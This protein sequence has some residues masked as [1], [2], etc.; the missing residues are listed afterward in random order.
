[1]SETKTYVCVRCD[2]VFP[3]MSSGRRS[4]SVCPSCNRAASDARA[5]ERKREKRAREKIRALRARALIGVAYSAFDAP[6]WDG[7]IR[8]ALRKTAFA[9]GEERGRAIFR[10]QAATHGD[11]FI[12]F[13]LAMRNAMLEMGMRPGRV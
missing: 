8:A 4:R 2:G 11:L 10:Q 5:V 1:M 12:H 9:V 6:V 13:A 7:D 3:Y